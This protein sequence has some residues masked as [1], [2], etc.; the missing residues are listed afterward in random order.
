MKPTPAFSM[1]REIVSGGALML[2]P[3]AARTSD[4]PERE[5]AALFPCLATG[6]PQPA[7]IIATAV[8]MLNVPGAVAAGSAGVDCA[9]RRDD[10]QRS[11]PHRLGRRNNFVNGFPA[12][13]KSEEKIGD[14]LFFN[15]IIKQR[16]HRQAHFRLRQRSA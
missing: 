13:P 5:L 12:R 4:D 16:I 11:G 6:T 2:T 3:S 1:H 15:L 14:I 9:F 7:T 8:E 10:R